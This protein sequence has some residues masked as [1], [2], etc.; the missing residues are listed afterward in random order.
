VT[1]LAADV[2]EPA[3][4]AALVKRCARELPPLAGVAHAAM[5]LDDGVFTAMSAERVARVMRPKAR[6]A[7]ALRRA[8]AEL[9]LDFFLL[10]SSIASLTGGVG[11]SNYAAANA[12]LDGFA[13]E[14]RAQGCP[15][16][17]V[18]WGVLSESGVVARNPELMRLLAGQGML[19]M[20]DDEALAGL[21]MALAGSAP[22]VACMKLD[23]AVFASDD[24]ASGFAGDLLKSARA[25]GPAL[26]RGLL[27]LAEQLRESPGANPIELAEG[28]IG[29]IVAT[30]LRTSPDRLELRRPLNA[31]GI[32][33]LMATELSVAL[34]REFGVRFT[35]LDLLRTLSAADIA[36]QVLAKLK[37]APGGKSE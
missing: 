28:C 8:T 2:G 27:A 24:G 6:G 1:T 12:F 3:A 25:S 11:Q 31:A 23:W 19:G 18:N 21:E 10:F 32:D 17:A 14:L 5:V 7:V 20:S 15:A 9:D 35:V 4:V 13:H 30:V 36:A 16:L 34:F 26:A 33:S 22:Q 37:P 29:A